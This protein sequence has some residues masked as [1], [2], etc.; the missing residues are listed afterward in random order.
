MLTATQVKVKGF[1]KRALDRTDF[2]EDNRKFNHVTGMVGINVDGQE[3]E[4]GIT[5]LNWIMNRNKPYNVY[6]FCY[7][8][9][10]LGVAYPSMVSIYPK[11]Q[12]SRKKED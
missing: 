7:C 1:N 3:K 10:N 12:S 11:N 5:R 9:G 8:A 2:S 4:K 6:R